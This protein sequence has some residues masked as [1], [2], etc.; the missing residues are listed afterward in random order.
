MD[1]SKHGWA[2]VLT[3]PYEEIDESTPLAA[4]TLLTKI[5]HQPVAYVSGLFRGGQLNWAALTKQAY[6]IYMSA[7]RLSFYLTNADVLIR[8]DHLTLKKFLNKNTMNAKVNNW[9][10]ELKTYNLKFEY[11]QGIK[12]DLANTLSRLIQLDPDVELPTEQPGQKFGYNFFEDL[13]PVKF[14]EIIIERIEIKPDPDTFLKE[15]DLNFLLKPRSIRTLQ[16]QDVKINRILKRLKVGDVDANVYMIEDGILKRRIMEQTG[17]EFKPIVLPK[18]MVDHVLIMAH[19][20][21]R[22]N[23]FPRMYAAIRHVYF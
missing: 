10:V 20:H 5:I 16:A 6:A 23:R 14:G 21:S 9:A 22:H 3:Q 11:I 12:N 15:I 1:A 17:D 2:G 4:E 8:S 7:G 13:P 19:D 18:S